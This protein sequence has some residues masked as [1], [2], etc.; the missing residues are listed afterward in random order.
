MKTYSTVSGDTWDKIAHSEMG[1]SLYAQEL[2]T[3]N[4]DFIN[5]TIFP[6][7]ISLTIPTVEESLSSNLPPWKRDGF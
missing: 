3:A 7:G 5:F 2:M 6:A 4:I 1:N